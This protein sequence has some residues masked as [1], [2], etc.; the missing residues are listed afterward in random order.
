MLLLVTYWMPAFAG[1]TVFLK[2]NAMARDAFDDPSRTSEDIQRGSEAARN[3]LSRLEESFK[4]N[5]ALMREFKTDLND[6]SDIF[7]SSFSRALGHAVRDGN[8]LG[9]VFD[10][11]RQSLENTA[12]RIGVVNPITDMIFGSTRLSGENITGGG[13]PFLQGGG[14]ILGA[15]SRGLSEVIGARAFGGPVGVGQ[16]FVVGE[17]GPELFVP[18]TAGRIQANVGA[19]PV[20]ITMNIATPDA[21]SFRAS[22]TQV[23]AQML[24]AARRA[25]RIR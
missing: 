3:S 8:S 13:S 16:P 15:L 14:G 2:E 19:A 22:Q 4:A 11:L 7:R 17:R 6:V 24:D 23:A 1:M 9:T 25:Q 12:L 20:H 5:R 10:K 21:S 18:Q